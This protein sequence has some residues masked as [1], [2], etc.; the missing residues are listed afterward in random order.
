MPDIDYC[1]F[2]ACRW[3]LIAGRLP[4]RTDNEIKNYWNTTLG[5]KVRGEQSK[6][7]E[8]E[9]KKT[10]LK[11]SNK[12]PL[13]N[14][15][16]SNA[17]RPKAIRTKASTFTEVPVAVN[18]T[19]TE[20]KMDSKVVTE[21][22][23]HGELVSNKD[24]GSKTSGTMTSSVTSEDINLQDFAL[25]FCDGEFLLFDIADSE[26]WKQSM[27]DHGSED[28]GYSGAAR[29]KWPSL[30]QPDLMFSEELMLKDWIKYGSRH[31]T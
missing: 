9:D 17:I 4:G 12:T 11:L 18:Q 28:V 25:D 31:Q 8:N 15:I 24:V 3:S 6:Q 7:S 27:L 26:F 13:P 29:S 21:A 30:D 1:V 10:K 5:K 23:A 22:H 20:D 14:M 2:Q 19:P 16:E